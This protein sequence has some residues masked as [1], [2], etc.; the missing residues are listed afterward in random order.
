MSSDQVNADPADVRKLAAAL[1]DLERKVLEATKQAHQ[2]IDRA[3]WHDRQKQMFE[4]R[5]RDFHKHTTSFVSGQV[6]EFAK[7]LNALAADLE[8]AKAHRF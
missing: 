3:N 8:R 4:T 5:Y 7:S 2:A 1:H 6:R